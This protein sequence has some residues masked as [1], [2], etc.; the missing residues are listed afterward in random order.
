MTSSISNQIKV[1]CPQKV[2]SSFTLRQIEAHLSDRP[3]Q[4][5]KA[6]WVGDN[7]RHEA[8][9]NSRSIKIT[10][11]SHLS[12]AIYG[13]RK[14]RDRLRG[15][16]GGRGEGKRQGRQ[17]SHWEAGRAARMGEFSTLAQRW[18]PT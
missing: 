18:R 16:G 7:E 2:I 10:A 4:P 14:T 11:S 17:P 6:P 15:R 3:L 8:V 1:L 12:I 13:H 5:F 9:A